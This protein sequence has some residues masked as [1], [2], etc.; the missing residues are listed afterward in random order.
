M[1]TLRLVAGFVVALLVCSGTAI[2]LGLASSAQAVAH[3][4]A[5]PVFAG[6]RA[7]RILSNYPNQQFP[8][9]DYWVRVGR[10]MADKFPDAVPAGEWIVSLYQENGISELSFPS[11]GKSYPYVR[12]SDTDYNEAYL[13]EFDRS[14]LKIWLQVEPGA[15]DVVTLI[16][17]VV[18]RYRHHVCVAGFAVDVEWY[19]AN[20]H[21]DG[22]K[23]TDNEAQKWEQHLKS[24]DANYSLLLKHWEQAWMPPSYRGDILF[25]DDSQRFSSLHDIV[26]EF[27]AWGDYFSPNPV[28]FQFG[29]DSDRAWWSRYAD[30][31]KTIGNAILANVTNT[32]GLF[33]ADFTITDVFPVPEFG[34]SGMLFITILLV[35]MTCLLPRRRRC[36][37]PRSDSRAPT[38]SRSIVT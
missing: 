18:Q 20:T 14:G 29:Y 24:I 31:P 32:R 16:D 33:W 11:S 28:G 13:D 3:D 5:G 9:P 34:S 2:P 10:E 27:S 12:F 22:Q 1:D 36:A 38:Q 17:V 15:V 21:R 23:V 7:S 19:R 6:F 30:P 37:F 8:E 4:G 25:I 35:L 26:E